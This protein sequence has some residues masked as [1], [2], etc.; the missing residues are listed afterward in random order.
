MRG[1][2][3]SINQ[4]RQYLIEKADRTW[5]FFVFI[6]TEDEN[7]GDIGRGERPL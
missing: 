7:N 3:L 5:F 2:P 4:L 1:R 6:M